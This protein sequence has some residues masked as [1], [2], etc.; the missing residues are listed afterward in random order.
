MDS[1]SSLPAISKEQIIEN[2]RK[3][4]L[5]ARR[6][7]TL[8]R[9]PFGCIITGPDNT[10]LFSQGN[11]DTLN[12]AESTACRTA[13]SNLSP[14]VLAQCTLYTNFEP[15]AMCAGSMYWANIGRVVYGASE[16]RLLELTGDDPE[17]MT[18][19]LPCREVFAKGQKH[20]EV[21]GPF[22]EIEDEIMKDHL[23]FWHSSK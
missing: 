14:E 6:A 2:L 16:K 7:K 11:I 5:I 23:E 1:K 4:I 21:H 8:G 3:A 13:W 17:N 20:I 15:C 19:S 22:P 18:L 12:H 10:V 9:H